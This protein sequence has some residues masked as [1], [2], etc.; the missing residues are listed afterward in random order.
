MKLLEES[1]INDKLAALGIWF[2]FGDSIYPWL[3]NIRTYHKHQV[4]LRLRIHDRFNMAAYDFKSDPESEANSV[5]ESVSESDTDSDTN[6]DTNTD[7]ESPLSSTA[8]S[9]VSPRRSPTPS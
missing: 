5:S 2:A 3:S 6:T 4:R 7:T 8:S 1:N 9:T